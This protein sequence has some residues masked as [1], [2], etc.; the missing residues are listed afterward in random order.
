M[1]PSSDGRRGSRSQRATRALRRTPTDRSGSSVAIRTL[2]LSK[3]YGAEHVGLVP[4]QPFRATAAI[5]MLGL[6]IACAA[7]AMWAFERRDLV[8]S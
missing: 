3:S 6:A 2:R 8:A 4:A 5:V 1:P 7:A